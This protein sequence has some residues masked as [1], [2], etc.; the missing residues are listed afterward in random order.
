MVELVQ[1]S[2]AATTTPVKQAPSASD[3]IFDSDASTVGLSS[4]GTDEEFK[5]SPVKEQPSMPIIPQQSVEDKV[6]IGQAFYAWCIKNGVRMPKLEYPFVF[7]DGTVG[8]RATK[9]ITHKEAYLAVPMSLAMSVEDA[10]SHEI[11]GKVIE[12]NPNMFAPN[13]DWPIWPQ[14]ILTLYLI[15][16]HLKGEDSFWKPYVDT[17]QAETPFCNWT[18]ELVLAA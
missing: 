2:A 16:E 1:Q 5:G 9:P 12:E 7:E 6:R 18:D 11:L 17:I 10:Q 14:M 4:P 3:D 8:V 15:H 13:G